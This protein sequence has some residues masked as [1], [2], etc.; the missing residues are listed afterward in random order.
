MGEGQ[1]ALAFFQKSLKVID[2]L[3][4]HIP[5]R[6]DFRKDLS[7]S[8][9]DLAQIFQA[10]G[11]VQKALELFEKSLKLINELIDIEPTRIEYRSLLS[12]Y[13][14][15]VGQIYQVMGKGQKVALKFFEN[16]LKV[17]EDLIITEPART[18]FKLALSSRLKNIG[19]IYQ[20]MG[21]E[22][23]ALSFFEKLKIILDELVAL[24][25]NRT[26]IRIE[27]SICFER[28]GGIYQSFGEDQI[29][30]DL[31]EK[32]KNIMEELVV[33]E[34]DRVDFRQEL[35]FAMRAR[36]VN[37]F[38]AGNYE[39]SKQLFE[40]LLYNNFEIKSTHMHLARLAIITD[41][42]NEAE[43]HTNEAWSMRNDSTNY[44]LARILWFKITLSL[45]NNS[46]LEDLLGQLKTVLQ[47]EDAIMEWTMAPVLEYIKPKLPENEHAL[48]TALVAAMSY[49][50]N[51]EKLDKIPEWKNA[52]PEELD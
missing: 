28:L 45:L 14:N 16:S 52:K 37:F 26:D 40:E 3:S 36:A 19:T 41:N 33:L 50:E 18:D 10:M 21:E 9:N 44:V 7:V 49:E 5:E 38:K 51:I 17:I 11:E 29:A 46:S 15:N 43:K 25:P 8:F 35:Y 23:K 13:L 32:R 30:F 22:Q 31:F 34:P 24:E 27:L 48:L 20:Y 12:L 6:L 4:T 2:E 39:N 42:Y 47:K 1:K